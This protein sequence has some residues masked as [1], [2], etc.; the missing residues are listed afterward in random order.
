MPGGFIDCLGKS[1]L[2]PAERNYVLAQQQLHIKSGLGED[3][4]AIE[5]VKNLHHKT[6]DSLNQVYSDLK[7][8]GYA[9]PK[10]SA[11]KDDV[12]KAPGDSSKVGKGDEGQGAKP[13]EPAI[14]QTPGTTVVRHGTSVEDTQNVLSGQ[15]QTPITEKSKA[16]EIP[17]LIQDLQDKGISPT[18]VYSSDLMRGAQ[19][20]AEV[21]KAFGAEHIQDP[22]LRS[23]D[24]GEFS[25]TGDEAFK[26]AQ[27]FFVDNPDAKEFEG[28]KLGESF[29][30]YKNR[31]IK[32]RKNIPDDPA[33]LVVDHSNNMAVNDAYEKNGKQWNDQAK[34]DYMSTK[35]AAPAELPDKTLIKDQPQAF[36][37]FYDTFKN[38][39]NSV[40]NSE[41]D[42]RV[43]IPDMTQSEREAAVRDI[44]AGKQTK[45]AEKFLTALKEQHDDGNIQY[46]RGRGANVEKMSIPTAKWNEA[47]EYVVRDIGSGFIPM[48]DIGDLFEQEIKRNDYGKEKL[49]DV[50]ES[51][52]ADTG[53]NETD[54]KAG[55]STAGAGDEKRVPPDGKGKGNES[56]QQDRGNE[57][58]STNFRTKDEFELGLKKALKG[59][60]SDPV[61][62][63]LDVSDEQ[64]RYARRNS[65]PEYKKKYGG[66]Q[67][68]YNI[69]RAQKALAKVGDR[70]Q[71]VTPPQY[72]DPVKALQTIRA[73][74]DDPLMNRAA[75]FLE[76]IMK[77]NPNIHIEDADLGGRVLGLSHP[78]GRIQVDFSAHGS[79]E[80]AHRTI[81]HELFHA[82]TRNEIEKNPAFRGE[83]RSML[84][85]IR[86]QMGLPKGNVGDVLIPE[87]VRRDII[88]ADKYGT[89]NEHE[90]I[91][92][93]FSNQKFRDM[94]ADMKVPDEHKKNM[95][96]RVY[97]GIVRYF[98]RQYD[99]LKNLKD[100]ISAPNMAEHLMQL[101]EGTVKG[102]KTEG[103]AFPKLKGADEEDA[104]ANM[105]KRAPDSMTD[106]ELKE[107]IMKHSSLDEAKVDELIKA[108]GLTP[109]VKLSHAIQDIAK[110]K[111]TLDAKIDAANKLTAQEKSD[112]AGSKVSS[113][114]SPIKKVFDKLKST[115]IAVKDAYVNKPEW[116]SMDKAIGEYSYSKQKN[117]K[118]VMDMVNH[119]T[120]MIPDKGKREAI[121][122]WIE[123]GGDM[124]MLKERAEKSDAKHKGGYIL[125]QHLTPSE[126]EVAKSVN[127]YFDSMFKTGNDAGILKS[128]LEDYMT[129]I[130]VKKDNPVANQLLT[131]IMS[132]KINTSFKYAKE[133]TYQTFFDLEQAGY[134][135]RTKDFANI[136]GV[137]S[138]SFNKALYSRA[139]IKN[140][141]DGKA[142]D[143]R[144][145][146]VQA[147]MGK[148]IANKDYPLVGEPTEAM[149]VN[150]FTAPEK[151]SD[152]RP[153]NH[154]ALRDWYWA[155]KDDAG[156]PVFA[157][158]DLLVHPE[159]YKRLGNILG[160]SALKDYAVG[161]AA[162]WGSNIVKRTIF[163]VSPFFHYVQEGTHAI[164]HT[165]NPISGLKDVNFNDETQANLLKHG[166]KL[167]D[168]D[169]QSS[170]TEGL[171]A[172]NLLKNLPIYNKTILPIQE[173]LFNSYIP[174][175]K[176]QTALHAL[177]RN[178]KRN[179]NALVNDKISEDAI[180][181]Q[182]GEQINAAYGHL[183]YDMIGRNKTAQ[184]VFSM[185]ALAP[186]FLEARAR[187]VGQAFTKHG[188]EQ[189]RALMV[190]AATMYVTA[191]ILNKSIDGDYHFEEPFAVIHGG[192]KY[193][194]RSVPEDIWEMIHDPG[195]FMYNR[196][197][198]YSQILFEGATKFDPVRGRQ[199][200]YS[201]WLKDAA[202]TPLPTAGKEFLPDSW[203]KFPSKEGH[204]KLWN[205]FINTIGV[206]ESK[207]YTPTEHDII[208]KFY[209]RFPKGE[210]TES[211]V[212]ES[213]IYK[214]N[215]A[216]NDDK[217]DELMQKLSPE[218][219][220]S[221]KKN[222]ESGKSVYESMFQR[223]P[224]EDKIKLFQNMTDEE[225]EKYDPK[226]KIQ[227]LIDEGDDNSEKGTP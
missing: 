188:T 149:M 29:N 52:S 210:P 92:E 94:L 155:T 6:L 200:D 181:R 173:H 91:A 86:K 140:A 198:P 175:L 35:N 208:D 154:F 144:P 4:A 217:V 39:I 147:G 89:S 124:N 34:E 74:H 44:D 206:R 202:T 201:E 214:A 183:N 68:E 42:W 150:P 132:G 78:D 48:K 135:A 118:E 28:K 54:A 114:I 159:E 166:L 55:P 165:I 10:R 49:P 128:Q 225:K 186:D 101:T 115:A 106:Q 45:R 25:K 97:E 136:L 121:S 218:Q 216:G 7:I 26:P 62:P 160:H 145:L 15:S 80:D 5:S 70:G 122:N 227:K 98:N 40:K 192:Q 134:S 60:P 176:M 133:R 67:D 51:R 27:R 168:Y 9:V 56:K 88:P 53:H 112:I 117:D 63:K 151:Y 69:V 152:Y 104:I 137:Y 207:A 95:L 182:T 125:A 138:Q 219:Q 126:I 102:G 50:S 71:G 220:K 17:K 179:Q 143:G 156:N 171:S 199:I 43:N 31:V 19:T 197:S 24:L 153:I 47:E 18:K 100:K 213:K 87:L 119:L 180:Y 205:T 189:A 14:P 146:L 38:E 93:V 163:S 20:A 79:M 139:F 41:Y 61:V 107:S 103:E 110:N 36:K 161:R 127:D 158:G 130:G 11:T 111:K 59:P 37:D 13:E 178:M 177:D 57:P 211:A 22:N 81:L 113:A 221:V 32:A 209:K 99:A 172:N 167:Y 193:R 141:T 142:S 203:N 148:Q 215:E 169:S 191:R 222:L 212:T 164:G 162:M 131:D 185:L 226:G 129:H 33:N 116:K 170:F 2:S 46:T 30:E 109:E 76:P 84:E 73:E 21:A 190:L 3:E 187:F 195:R 96:Q 85:E 64:I 77:A 223:L 82:A 8:K 58:V 75:N 65:Y 83:V 105:V 157:K 12:V 90:L 174:R 72:A 123:A 194:L 1:G 108:R 120:K 224:K 16:E 196:I 184:D 23:W 66:T 204:E